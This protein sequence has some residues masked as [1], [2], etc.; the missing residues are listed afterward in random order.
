MFCALGVRDDT[1]VRVGLQFVSSRCC[2][3]K[4]VIS[5]DLSRGT[6]VHEFESLEYIG[7]HNLR[8]LSKNNYTIRQSIKSHATRQRQ[9]KPSFKFLCHG[10][11]AKYDVSLSLGDSSSQTATPSKMLEVQVPRTRKGHRVRS[12]LPR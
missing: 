2:R 5:Y 4:G 12:D 6:V 11:H 3:V 7:S 9:S 10:E 8:T 1:L